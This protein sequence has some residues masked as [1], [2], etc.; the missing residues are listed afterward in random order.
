MTKDSKP[1]KSKESIEN[2]KMDSYVNAP[3]RW[4]KTPSL[5][6]VHAE[7]QCIVLVNEVHTT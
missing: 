3:L 2:A 5:K 1:I 7:I 6:I 4:Q